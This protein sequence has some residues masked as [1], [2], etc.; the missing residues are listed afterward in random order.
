MLDISAFRC[1]QM[2]GHF[3]LTICVTTKE[4]PIVVGSALTRMCLCVACV[5]RGM[6]VCRYVGGRR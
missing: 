1:T 4:S 6:L 2:L 5:A 3:Y